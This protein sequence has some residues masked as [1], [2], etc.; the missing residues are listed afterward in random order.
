MPITTPLLDGLDAL[1]DASVP[2]E[3]ELMP[4]VE[5]PQ[6]PASSA[7]INAT[8][9]RAPDLASLRSTFIMACSLQ[10]RDATESPI[11]PDRAR[12][13]CLITGLPRRPIRLPLCSN[14]S[15]LPVQTRHFCIVEHAALSSSV[16]IPLSTI[17]DLVVLNTLRGLKAGGR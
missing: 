8:N 2:R 13:T 4:E 16:C 1:A 12:G 10:E 9:A 5:L 11:L 17:C 14:T 3:A 15:S 7:P 6:A